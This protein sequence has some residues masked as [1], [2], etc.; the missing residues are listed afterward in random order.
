MERI[1]HGQ[2]VLVVGPSGAGKDTLIAAARVKHAGNER[3]VFPRRI[4]TRAAN[5]FEDHDTI[6]P[7]GFRAA[8]DAHGYALSWEAHGLGYG[9]PLTIDDDIGAG[10]VVVANVSRGSIDD[11][12]RRYRFVHI[13]YVF[14]T[15]EVLAARIAARGREPASE[16]RLEDRTGQ[17]IMC[18]RIDNS[19]E[20]S[21]AIAAFLR[22]L[23]LIGAFT[24]TDRPY[25]A[26]S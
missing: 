10:R 12:A 8:V 15:P 19:G 16:S 3:F 26:S 6:S 11:A 2:L 23:E 13:V 7:E 5:A 14:A 1:G 9:L 22:E 25:P 21:V 4:V 20:A 24:N 17:T 18:T